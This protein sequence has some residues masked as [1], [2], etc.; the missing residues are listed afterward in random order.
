M[1]VHIFE[2]LQ[3][4]GSYIGDL[5]YS[6]K[7]LLRSIREVKNGENPFSSIIRISQLT[8]KGTVSAKWWRKN[9]NTIVDKM[10]SD[11]IVEVWIGEGLNDNLWDWQVKAKS[12]YYIETNV[13]FEGVCV[14]P[15]TD[16]GWWWKTSERE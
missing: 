10:H 14:Y 5:L 15:V 11:R 13:Y 9:F 3:L 6:V 16:N 7:M 12:L 2:S 1:H 8:C 4:E